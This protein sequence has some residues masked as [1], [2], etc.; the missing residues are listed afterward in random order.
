M[1]KGASFVSEPSLGEKTTGQKT[2]AEGELPTI[3]EADGDYS[4]L[5]KN[6]FLRPIGPQASM[7]EA[8]DCHGAVLIS[9]R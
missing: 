4:P 8:A 5:H 6:Y 2:D 1:R 7:K 9:S 3:E